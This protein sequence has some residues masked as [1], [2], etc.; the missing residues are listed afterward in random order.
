MISYIMKIPLYLKRCG[1]YEPESDGIG[2]AIT[3]AMAPRMNRITRSGLRDW[4]KSLLKL[5]AWVEY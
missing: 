4:K 1:L 5:L 3:N 2:I